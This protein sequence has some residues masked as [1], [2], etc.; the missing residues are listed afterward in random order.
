MPKKNY[1]ALATSVYDRLKLDE[2]LAVILRELA[3]A[4]YRI[5]W[6]AAAEELANHFQEAAEKLSISMDSLGEDRSLAWAP[7]LDRLEQTAEEIR[8]FALTKEEG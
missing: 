5:G 8:Q 7:I 4:D 1:E 3:K 6:D 2:P